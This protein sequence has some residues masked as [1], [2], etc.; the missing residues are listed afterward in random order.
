MTMEAEPM[1]VD[2]VEPSKPASIKSSSFELPWVRCRCNE[3]LSTSALLVLLV[4]PNRASLEGA[5]LFADHR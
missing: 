5:I 3:L 1:D 4:I 2:I